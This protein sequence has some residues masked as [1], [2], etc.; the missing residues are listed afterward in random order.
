MPLSHSLI[1]VRR[2][3]MPIM[4][5]VKCNRDSHDFTGTQLT[6]ALAVFKSMPHQLFVP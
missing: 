4:G 3:E 2:F 5:L 6:M 1:E